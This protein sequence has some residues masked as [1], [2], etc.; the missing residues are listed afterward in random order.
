MII[1]WG[2]FKLCVDH[3]MIE[4]GI[5]GHVVVCGSCGTPL[6]NP[7]KPVFANETQLAYCDEQCAYEDVMAVAEHHRESDPEWKGF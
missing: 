3:R 6:K 2:V 4:D 5:E 7:L 1:R